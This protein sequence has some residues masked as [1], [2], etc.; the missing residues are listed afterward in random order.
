[1]IVLLRFQS[2][3]YAPEGGGAASFAQTL[4]SLKLEFSA[5]FRFQGL[6]FA[7]PP[8]MP[9]LVGE[10]CA[11][12]GFYE[13]LGQLDANYTRSPRTRTLMSSCSTP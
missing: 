6:H 2:L 3:L 9:F 8:Q 7:E 12:E 13:I 11:Y 5:E 10:F 1:M 4:L